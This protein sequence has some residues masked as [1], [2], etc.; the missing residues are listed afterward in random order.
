VSA[1]HPRLVWLPAT[2]PAASVRQPERPR[3]LRKRTL[4]LALENDR[5]A[6]A[7][8]RAVVGGAGCA[9]GSLG[10]CLRRDLERV[11]RSRAEVHGGEGSHAGELIQGL[12]KVRGSYGSGGAVSRR[13]RWRARSRVVYNGTTFVARLR[14][15]PGR[16][17]DPHIV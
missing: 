8:D 2:Q 12:Y 6:E 4:G 3:S 17:A 9:R 13:G 16:T 11:H 10:D 15:R 1:M 14:R 5:R 7:H